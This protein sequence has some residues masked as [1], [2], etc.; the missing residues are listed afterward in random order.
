VSVCYL[1]HVGRIQHPTDSGSE[2]RVKRTGWGNTRPVMPAKGD[3]VSGMTWAASQLRI[4]DVVRFR[5][6]GSSP[7][8]TAHQRR[9][10]G[11]LISRHPP[12]MRHAMFCPGL[13]QPDR[14]PHSYCQR[15]AQPT[16]GNL[17]QRSQLS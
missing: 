8:V 2:R 5:R 16:N 9:Q 11:M 15:Q 1:K 12:T 17:K 4:R 13:R 14:I 7:S 10:K 6:H 3:A